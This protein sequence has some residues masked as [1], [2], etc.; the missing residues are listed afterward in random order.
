MRERVLHNLVE[1]ISG[2]A[3]AAFLFPGEASVYV[4]MLENVKHLDGVRKMLHIARKVLGFDIL[5]TCINGPPERLADPNVAQ[6]V[7]G[8]LVYF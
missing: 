1:A 4:G 3:Q 5:D 8:I 6:A 2:V 7:R